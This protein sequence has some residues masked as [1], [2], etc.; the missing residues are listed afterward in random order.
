M[1]NFIQTK[2]EMILNTGM[3]L[4]LNKNHSVTELIIKL[5]KQHILDFGTYALCYFAIQ[6][7]M[8][9]ILN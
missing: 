3:S 8:N 5:Q 4:H 7:L 1:L 6:E 2:T 9:F